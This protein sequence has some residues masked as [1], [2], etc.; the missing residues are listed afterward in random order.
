VTPKYCTQC[1]GLLECRR[2]QDERHLQPV[3]TRCGHVEWQNP[4]PAVSALIMRQRDA[5]GS[6]EVLLGRRALPPREGYWDSP[7]GFI[8]PDEHPEDALR[9][10]L[11]EELGVE[12][13]IE[14][15]LGIF[16]DRYGDEGESTLNIYYQTTIASGTPAPASDVAEIR[17]FLLDELPD[18]IAFESNR[19][20]LQAMRL[21]PHRPAKGAEER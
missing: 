13:E 7:G 12:V 19:Q 4:K 2:L 10:E 15:L 14:T 6:T 17:W 21:G 1:A 5:H 18:A 8:D 20:V 11:R 3:C 16:M 9:R